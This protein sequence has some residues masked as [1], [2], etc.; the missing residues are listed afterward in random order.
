MT[1]QLTIMRTAAGSPPSVSQYRY[2]QRLGHRVVAGDCADLS[3]GFCFADVSYVL[4][5]ADATDY[6][7]TLIEICRQE[8]VDVFLPALDEELLLVSESLSR[9]KAVGT[10]ALVSSPA[11]LR[12]CVDKYLTFTEFEKHGIPTIPTWIATDAAAETATLPVVIKPRQGRGSTGVHVAK[13]PAEL[14]FFSQYVRDAVVQPFIAGTEYTVDVLADAQSNL[15]IVSPRKRLATD[16]GISSKGITAW[17]DEIVRHVRQIV[18]QFRIIGPANI[19]CFVT[20]DGRLLFSEINARLAGTCI[21]SIDAGVPLLEG[22][23]SMA[24]GDE[25]VECL[26][27]VTEQILLRYWSEAYVRPDRVIAKPSPK[28]S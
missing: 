19:Q 24:I 4:P 21:L 27:P 13:T 26:E 6:V 12:L 20:H 25:I 8:R 18:E 17:S 14:T 2:L 1:K 7:E 3:V 5:H 10:N 11:T 9:F 16:S 22:I 15:K 23:C 28:V